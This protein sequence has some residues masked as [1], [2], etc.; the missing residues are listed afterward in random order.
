MSRLIRFC[1]EQKLV[2]FL[3]LAFF[4]GWGVRVAPF[5]WK[6]GGF[7]RDPV[8]VDAIP[9]LGDNQQIVF[10]EWMGRSPQD[11]DDQVTYPLTVALLGVPQVREVRSYSYFGFSSIYLIFKEGTDFY[12]AR[13][14]IL[15]KLGSLPPGTLPEGTRPALGPD[16]TGLGQVF[17]YTLEG[18][19]PKGQPVGGWDLDELRAIQDWQVRYAL[20]AGGAVA[21]V[22]SIGGFAREYQ[23]DV[24]P[25]ALRANNVMLMDVAEAVR[26]ANAESGARNMAVNGVEYIIRATG[27]VRSLEDLR[28]AVVTVRDN[29][30]VTVGDLAT[31]QLGP[32]MRRGAL[33]KNGAEAVGG[34]VVARFG[35]N[36]LVA[37][38][39]TKEKIKELATGL[40]Q[41]V[42]VRWEM[43]DA[44]T[45]R[46]FAIKNHLPLPADGAPDSV[47]GDEWRKW[48]ATSDMEQWP[49]WLTLSKVTVVPFYD[50]SG[51]IR[52]TLG[53]L[54]DALRQEVLITIIVVMV[55]VLH[56]RGSLLISCM[57]PLAVLIT[58]VAMKLFGVDA[59][60]VALGGIAI[61]IGTVVDVGIVLTENILKHMHDAPPDEPV[62]ETIHRAATEVASAVITSVATTVVS[63]LPVFTLTGE[64]G[65]LYG[66]LAYTKSFALTASVIT[67]VV[68]IPP[69]AHLLM[70]RRVDRT[71]A[72]LMKS[73]KAPPVF[74]QSAFSL[75]IAFLTGCLLASDWMPLGLDRSTVLNVIFT[76]AIIG[77][78]LLFYRMVEHFYPSVLS[79]CLRR[80]TA[81]LLIP[82]GIIV[83]G[84]LSWRGWEKTFGWAGERVPSLA[85][86]RLWKDLQKTFPGLG[87]EFRPSLDE[88]SFLVMPTINP[89]ASMEEALDY[90]K[91]LDAAVTEVPEVDMVV[92]KLGRSDSALDPAPV[93]MYENIVNYKSEFI[94]DANGR[95][96][97][98]RYD[99]KNERF[100]FDEFGELIPDH[101]G[102]PFR[103]W[104]DHIRSPSDIWK[105]IEKRISIT[106]MTGAPQ[107]QPIETRLVMLQTGMRAPMG[108]KVRGPSLQAVESFGIRIEQLLKTGGVPG[109]AAGSVSAE[110]IVGKPYLEI[111]PDRDAIQR[112]GLNIADVHQMLELAIGGKTLTTTVEGRERF[113]VRVRYMREERDSIEALERV[114]ITS[115]EG[116]AIPLAE[117][118]EIR[119][120]RGPQ[121]IKSEDTF[122]T[123]FITFGHEPEAAP[124][125]VVLAAQKFL[126]DAEA[127][128]DLVRPL[129]VTYRFAGEY[130]NQLEFDR[131]FAVVLPLTL[132]AI[133]L[134]LYLQFRSSLI[135]LLV[136]TGVAI[137]WAGGFCLLWAYGQADFL[138][139]SVFGQN[140]RELFHVFPINLS[141]AV[142]VG[143]LALFGI[144][145]DDGVVI[146]TYL[147]QRFAQDEPKT[148]E[149]IR[150]SVIAAGTRRVRPCLMTT[151]TTV[152]AL[153]PV[154]TS[155][156]RGSDLMIA[157]AVPIFG[158]MTIEIITMF[159]VPVLFSAWKE[160]SAG[161]VTSDR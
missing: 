62:L 149:E 125:D 94:T 57:L 4:V 158:G 12:W 14:R 80:K 84:V 36:P 29:T 74:A 40:P 1:L 120:V 124:I 106:G 132:G 110:R 86:T 129:G 59:N 13:S 28:K 133:F 19:D 58:F 35:E 107:L 101:G 161:A 32:A 16:A 98:F 155:T 130:E 89:H 126:H 68:L 30:P 83:M 3:L 6:L 97:R 144:A 135:A 33:D 159:V 26:R 79:W 7:P 142:W 115:K 136:F 153:L 75:I 70:R 47:L 123:G 104:R 11:V 5:D 31:V 85:Q 63:F 119:F 141:T 118:A 87:G 53:T 96:R 157:M 56:L 25:N 69:I 150:A 51:L 66:P 102:R 112:Y 42:V 88:G 116:V 9:D 15:E 160:C 131:N 55:M 20:L 64:A 21:E 65:R 121:M 2:V 91:K 61:A 17:W 90:L 143:F 77:G 145:T 81:F 148:I 92:G 82:S 111:V 152:I 114:L 103:Q 18:R 37:I 140:L 93:S 41:R 48:L 117:I 128:G 27:Y 139:F 95:P 134:L 67:A 138:N 52:E 122:L 151:A 73:A 78:L 43:T 99:S 105:E 49:E 45:V 109:L 24:D 60:V 22:S 156:G 100:V 108:I 23:I 154:L 39:Q 76:V 46:A 10:T 137:A 50:R 71:A 113:A 147:R 54:E 34:V 8:P 44:D 127:R 38:Q 72:R 146:A